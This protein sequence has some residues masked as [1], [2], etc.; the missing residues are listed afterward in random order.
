MAYGRVVR[1]A[2]MAL[3]DESRRGETKVGVQASSCCCTELLYQTASRSLLLIAALLCHTPVLA[4]M[5]FLDKWN[6]P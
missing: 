6:G 1:G 2:Y 3:H 5:T 4:P